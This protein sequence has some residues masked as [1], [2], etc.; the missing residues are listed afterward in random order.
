MA[1]LATLG[2]AVDSRP[3]A[4]ATADLKAM[5]PAAREV[6]AAVDGMVNAVNKAKPAADGLSN[7][8]TRVGQNLAAQSSG[9][10]RLAAEYQRM[11]TMQ[12]QVDLAN[13]ANS[14]SVQGL[15]HDA[16]N[17]SFQLVDVTQGLLTGQPVFMI[18]AQQAGQIGQI[19]GTSPQGLGGL[20]KELGNAIGRILTPTRL[21]AAGIA[22]V[23]ATVLAAA[24]SWKTY[25][26]A[27]DDARR[28]SGMSSTAMAGLTSAA[29]FRGIGSDDFL[30][31]FREFAG[32]VAQAKNGVGDLAVQFRAMGQPIGTSQKA[33]ETLAD[34]IKNAAN[35]QQRLQIL[36]AAGLPTSRQWVD[37]MSQGADGI[38]EAVRQANAFGGAANDNMIRKAKE[39]DDAWNRGITNLRTGWNKLFLDVFGWFEQLSS[40]GTAALIKITS[41]LPQSL[42]P[43]IAGNILRTSMQDNVGSRLTQ[44]AADDFYGSVSSLF[45]GQ[46]AAATTPDPNKILAANQRA[47]QRISPLGDL[48]TVKD[49]QANDQ[50]ANPPQSETSKNDS[51]ATRHAA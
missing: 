29:G 22:A 18:F 46:N 16:R 19:I 39:F 10:Q 30:T 37:L 35:D 32:T 38:R 6:G 14:R 25:A 47:Q 48:A 17:L 27:V 34:A 23:G 11:T 44:S 31:Q 12:R 8:S 5:A 7:S 13:A 26:L 4:R 42:R 1:D 43:D 33:F 28:V 45:K 9:A 41:Y 36:A 24:S 3:L 15:S 49:R 21:A 2:F 50:R 20:M 51:G 40:K